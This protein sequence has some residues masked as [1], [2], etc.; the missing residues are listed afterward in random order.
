M[1]ASLART[2]IGIA[3]LAALMASAASA[4]AQGC[5]EDSKRP[6]FALTDANRLSADQINARL[7]GRRATFA[8][9]STAGVTL[10]LTAIWRPDGSSFGTCEFRNRMGDLAPCGRTSAAGG[11]RDVATWRISDPRGILCSTRT[12]GP[13]REEYCYSLHEQGGRYAMKLLSGTL[14]CLPGNFGLQ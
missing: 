9:I 1:E 4:R 13:D 8:R 11:G 3:A 2:A 14:V 5:T 10:R 12:G 6:S 7:I